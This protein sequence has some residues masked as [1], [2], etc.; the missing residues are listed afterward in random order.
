ML[1]FVV[2]LP[3]SQILAKLL[4]FTQEMGKLLTQIRKNV[5]R[6]TEAEKEDL[7]NALQGLIESRDPYKNFMDISN[8]HGG[9]Y[10]ICKDNINR[11][12]EACCPHQPGSTDF[13]IWHRYYQ[14]SKG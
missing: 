14:S 2:S 1:V 7:T 9:P 10:I 11:N 12:G 13:F 5:Q 3:F 8:F 6:L 4:H